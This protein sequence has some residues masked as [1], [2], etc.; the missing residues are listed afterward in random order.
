MAKKDKSE[1]AA[2]ASSRSAL[3]KIEVKEDYLV[4]SK[5]IPP[6]S[7]NVG[8]SEI[9]SVEHRRLVDYGLLIWVIVPTLVIIASNSF[10][11]IEDIVAQLVVEINLAM[12]TSTSAVADA[13]S[14]ATAD[15]VIIWFSALMVIVAAW[16]L[17]K[18]V[19]SLTPMLIVY[20]KGK[21]PIATPMPLTGDSMQ[22]LA[23][24]NKRVKE[25]SGLSKSEVEKIIGE[26]IRG[27][28]DQRMRMQ[29]D[30]IASMKLDIRA[31]KGSGDKERVKQIVQ[32]SIDKLEV[33][34]QLIDQELKKTGLSKDDIFK[35][36]RIKAPKDEFIDSVLKDE[37][38]EKLM[39]D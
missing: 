38:L 36:Y 28:L 37:G 27:L 7:R 34:D 10:K 6:I 39:N 15:Q 35:K 5:R 24:I 11:F 32:E 16:Y 20:R 33:Q 8:Y 14:R 1:E 2:I 19:M 23:E 12:G 31:A 4:I 22:V 9:A 29:Q 17:S 26:Q 13:S 21:N 3:H 18:F 25:S 30:L